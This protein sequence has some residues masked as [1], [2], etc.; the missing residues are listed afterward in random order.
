MSAQ[1]LVKNPNQFFVEKLDNLVLGVMNVS[2]L[3]LEEL[4]EN[5]DELLVVGHE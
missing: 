3:V 1:L 4:H 5:L 2:G